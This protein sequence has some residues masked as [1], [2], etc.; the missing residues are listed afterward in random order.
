MRKAM[1]VLLAA[2]GGCMSEGSPT[3]ALAP[4]ASAKAVGSPVRCID[5]QQISARRVLGPSSLAF[6]VAGTTYRNDLTENCPGLGRGAQFKIIQLEVQGGQLCSGDS[7]QA[8]D[9]GEARGVGSQAFPRC[10]LGAFTPIE[11]R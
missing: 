6:E 7:F 2:L 5:P 8:Y 1:I 4:E 10:R 9:P 3:T 11:T